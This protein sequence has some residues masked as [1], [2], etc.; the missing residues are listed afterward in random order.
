MES[1]KGGGR[2]MRV[3]SEKRDGGEYFNK[4]D[5]LEAR[6]GGKG[7]E[8]IIMGFFMWSRRKRGTSATKERG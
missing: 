2:R 5:L 7:P 1:N 4:A 6:G 3:G 8:E